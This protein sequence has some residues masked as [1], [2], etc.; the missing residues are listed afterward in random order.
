MNP[1]LI[2][3]L[4]VLVI[5]AALAS[6]AT[7]CKTNIQNDPVLRLSAAASPRLLFG[8]PSWMM[9]LPAALLNFGAA[10]IGQRAITSRLTDSLQVD[11]TKTQDLLGWEPR[12]S[13]S[14]GLRQT[15]RSF[16]R[17]D[18]DPVAQSA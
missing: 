17:L 12:R 9:P 18:L 13:V 14:E 1:I 8:R 2:R 11:V 4:L 16:Q 7:S 15:A 6:L 5:A 10:M 3:R